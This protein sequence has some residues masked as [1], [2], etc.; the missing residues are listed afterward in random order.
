MSSSAS[1]IFFNA[2]LTPSRQTLDMSFPKSSFQKR[3]PLIT[4]T[5]VTSFLPSHTYNSSLPT[6]GIRFVQNILPYC[7]IS[8]FTPLNVSGVRVSSK[9][10]FAKT[11]VAHVTL[12]ATSSCV[13]SPRRFRK[14]VLT[15]AHGFLYRY[16][17]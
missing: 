7:I 11:S 8:I 1:T 10:F 13:R 5:C 3:P 15:K 6:F 14:S 9:T 2:L 12:A 4:T 16:V 17:G